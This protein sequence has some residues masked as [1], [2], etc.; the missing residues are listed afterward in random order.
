MAMKKYTSP[1]KLEVFSGEEAT[2]VNKHL[3]KTGKAVSDF[4]D[5]EKEAFL[6]DLEKVRP[7]KEDDTEKEAK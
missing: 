2:V 4:S 7:S 1:E 5:E 3:A 6:S